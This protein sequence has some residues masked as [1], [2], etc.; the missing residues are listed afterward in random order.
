[1]RRPARAA[2]LIDAEE[3][4]T[5]L[6]DVVGRLRRATRRVLRRD[7]PHRPL[8]EAEL[9][10]LR[11]VASHR[12]CRVGD[13]AE[14]LGLAQNTVSTLVGRL[15]DRGLLERRVDARDPRAASLVMTPGAARRMGAWRR[16]RRLV[17]GRALAE[18]DAADREAI[19]AAEPALAR[20]VQ[21]LENV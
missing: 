11:L 20:L 14:V 19:R 15:V 12:G 16:R 17:V 1:M 21:A 2:E 8:T 13:A 4:A 5:Q 18:L 9:E 10:L 6:M 3:I 7:W